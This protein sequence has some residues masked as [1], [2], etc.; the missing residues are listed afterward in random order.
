MIFLQLGYLSQYVRP[1]RLFPPLL[2]PGRTIQLLL[3]PALNW[4]GVQIGFLVI[5]PPDQTRDGEDDRGNIIGVVLR[6]S[7]LLLR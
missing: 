4:L 1:I 3:W 5:A 7:I 2:L 6:V